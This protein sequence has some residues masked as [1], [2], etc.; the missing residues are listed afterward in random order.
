MFVVRDI[1]QKSRSVIRL[2]VSKENASQ[3]C[4]ILFSIIPFA[5]YNNSVTAAAAAAAAAAVSVSVSA[6][7]IMIMLIMIIIVITMMIMINR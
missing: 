5:H 2:D 1:C 6:T 7:T 3:H 4:V